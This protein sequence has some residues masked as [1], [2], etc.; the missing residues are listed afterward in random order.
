MKGAQR[1]SACSREGHSDAA[2]A[3]ARHG[4]AGHVS[5]VMSFCPCCASS[6]LQSV[7]GPDG[8]QGRGWS[9]R[10]VTA[11]QKTKEK[12]LIKGTRGSVKIK[13]NKASHVCLTLIGPR[14]NRV[15]PRCHS[16]SAMQ[17]LTFSVSLHDIPSKKGIHEISVNCLKKTQDCSH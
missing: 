4:E 8:P 13:V 7:V 3:V 5:V 10:A 2:R 17:T 9:C 1:R 14:E 6:L 12:I 15:L 16:D 11:L